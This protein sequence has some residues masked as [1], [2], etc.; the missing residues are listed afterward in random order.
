MAAKKRNVSAKRNVYAKSG[1]AKK[2]RGKRGVAVR[3]AERKVK[4][5]LL[6]G[7]LQVDLVTTSFAKLLE[8]EYGECRRATP[9]ESLYPVLDDDGL[10]YC[11]SHNPSHCSN[12][13]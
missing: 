6:Q 7:P 1:L 12:P 11:C 10:R 2:P 3:E 9:Y 8:S 13:L 4:D 5:K